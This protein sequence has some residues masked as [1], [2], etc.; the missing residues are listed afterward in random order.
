MKIFFFF[1]LCLSFPCRSSFSNF[2]HFT[3]NAAKF[4]PSCV[5]PGILFVKFARRRGEEK[6]RG[7][8]EKRRGEETRKETRKGKERKGGG[9]GI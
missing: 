6:R 9:A 3:L 1:S 5:L 4:K 7:D 2:L 8:E